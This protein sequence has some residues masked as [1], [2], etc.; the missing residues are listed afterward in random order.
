MCAV[1]TTHIIDRLAFPP[2]LPPAALDEELERLRQEASSLCAELE[3]QLAAS[4]RS[5]R[6]QDDLDRLDT[7][8]H[9]LGLQVP[10]LRRV[11]A[12]HSLLLCFMWPPCGLLVVEVSAA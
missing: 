3:E 11:A 5:Q 4:A 10:S 12:A 1:H 7:G 6:L 2:F 9:L 8:E